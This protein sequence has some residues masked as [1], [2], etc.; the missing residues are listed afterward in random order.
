M[1]PLLSLKLPNLTAYRKSN[2]YLV[3]A[4][5]A[6]YS[7]ELMRAVGS[8]APVR[9]AG[10]RYLY[11]MQPQN[12]LLK[13]FVRYWAILQLAIAFHQ[14]GSCL[15]HREEDS[16]DRGRGLTVGFRAAAVPTSLAPPDILLLAVNIWFDE[17]VPNAGH[18]RIR[19]SSG[20]SLE[21][22]STISPQ[23]R[24]ILYT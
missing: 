23:E 22:L 8:W 1:S 20:L 6:L 24:H 10:G 14:W 16:S 7:L 21:T 2:V 12:K 18:L 3:S 4:S 17:F 15:L 13:L 9:T 11:L 5:V 19:W